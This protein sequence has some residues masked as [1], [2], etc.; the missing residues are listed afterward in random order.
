MARQ[1]WRG[2]DWHQVGLSGMRWLVKRWWFWVLTAILLAG[3]VGTCFVLNAPWA[4]RITLAN[5]QKVHQGMTRH[6]VDAILGKPAGPGRTMR[7]GFDDEPSEFISYWYAEPEGF[8]DDDDNG[9]I[10]VDFDLEGKVD[11]AQ[12]CRGPQ[13]RLERSLGQRFRDGFR[14]ALYRMGIRIER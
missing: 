7:L 3:P 11:G 2:E 13:L 9:F 8:Y 12:W 5:L 10:V 14:C 4:S 1:E 6:E